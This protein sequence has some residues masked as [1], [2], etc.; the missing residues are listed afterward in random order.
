MSKSSRRSSCQRASDGTNGAHQWGD[1]TRSGRANSACHSRGRPHKCGMINLHAALVHH[2][3][4]LA[5][6]DR[7]SHIS[8]HTLQDHLPLK[9]AAVELDHRL[10]SHRN[11]CL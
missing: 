11:R 7:L 5:V 6:A 10:P 2:F 3:L 1:R 8:A 9:M 4:E